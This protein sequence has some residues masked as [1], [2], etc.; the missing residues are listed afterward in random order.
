MIIFNSFVFASFFIRLRRQ[1]EQSEKSQIIIAVKRCRI[2]TSCLAA[3]AV[4]EKVATVCL[5]TVW[6]AILNFGEPDFQTLKTQSIFKASHLKPLL[7]KWSLLLPSECSVNAQK[8]IF[9][10]F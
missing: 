7:L 2:C 3:G 5:A 10:R 8:S 1:V 9:S 6:K 4:E